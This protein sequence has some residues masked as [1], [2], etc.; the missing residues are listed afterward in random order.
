MDY[1]YREHFF[2][3]IFIFICFNGVHYYVLLEWAPALMG[4]SPSGCLHVFFCANKLSLQQA[5]A[6][7]AALYA[8]RWQYSS[9]G[10]MSSFKSITRKEL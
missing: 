6:V 7:D 8:L 2:I 4:V 5:A 9:E 10:S 3:F 1:N